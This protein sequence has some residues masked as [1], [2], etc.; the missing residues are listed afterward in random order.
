MTVPAPAIISSQQQDSDRLA[1]GAA[2]SGVLA[3]QPACEEKLK[4][5]AAKTVA[6]QGRA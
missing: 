6:R 5:M 2:T 4:W 1:A 3:S